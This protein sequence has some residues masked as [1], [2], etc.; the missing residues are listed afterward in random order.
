MYIQTNIDYNCLTEIKSK[1]ELL[2]Y[3]L[4]EIADK[5]H[6]GISEI[7]SSSYSALEKI[8]AVIRLHVTMTFENP[9]KM[10]IHVNEW[11]FL[12]EKKKKIFKKRRKTY[13]DKITSIL[14]EGIDANNFK[15]GDIEFLKNCVLSSI[16]WLYTWDV[17]SKKNLNPL[18]IEKNIT[19]FILGGLLRK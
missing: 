11:R 18:E 5:F 8:K 1:Q 10:N 3:L 13:E 17:S 9:H 14:Q 19:E 16:R 7:E 15:N 4:F 2:D 12:D 6:K